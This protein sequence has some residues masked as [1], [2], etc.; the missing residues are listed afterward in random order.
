MNPANPSILLLIAMTFTEFQAT[1]P[2]E[3]G[4]TILFNNKNSAGWYLKN[5]QLWRGCHHGQSR[6]LETIFFMF[7]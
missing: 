7:H 5:P 2:A 3:D 6:R 1:A 4:F